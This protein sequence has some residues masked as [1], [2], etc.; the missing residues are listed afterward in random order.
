MKEIYTDS[1]KR[2]E[3]KI[4]FIFSPCPYEDESAINHVEN[5]DGVSEGCAFGYPAVV[6]RILGILQHDDLDII[7]IDGAPAA[8]FHRLANALQSKAAADGIELEL[9]NTDSILLGSREL[10]NR[11]LPY[12]PENLEDDPV[13]MFGR[14][15][16]QPYTTLF[17]PKKEA[18]RKQFLINAKKEGHKVVFYGAG[19]CSEGFWPLLDKMCFFDIANKTMFLRIKNNLYT[20]LGDKDGI[21]V[22]QQFRRI[23]YID[24]QLGIHVRDRL[25]Q[26]G[27]LDYYLVS[28]RDRDTMM[29]SH[30]SMRKLLGALVKRPLRCKPFYSEGVWGGNYIMHMRNLPLDQFRNIAWSVDM[31]G[32]DQS[33]VIKVDDKHYFELPFMTV[34]EEYPNEL[35]GKEIADRFG[36]LFPIRFSYD[37]TFHSSGNMSIQCHPGDAFCKSHF[38]E[39]GRQDEGYYVVATGHDAKTYLGFKNG[40]KVDDFC[41]MARK[42]E[43]DKTNRI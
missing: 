34:I 29:I 23:Y 16:D 32:M 17:D 30:E 27:K 24:F 21:P 12:L 18:E 20:A 42:S 11:L 38:G 26:E 35:L 40:V 31:N 2:K 39:Y 8:D 33:V 6:S 13:Q 43:T 25:I 14:L 19:S 15:Y 10:R 3:S 37:D 22:P 5:I 1:V 9:V 36:R 7:G 41:D 28:D 4:S